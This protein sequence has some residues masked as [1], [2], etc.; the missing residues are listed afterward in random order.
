MT[1][2][3]DILEELNLTELKAKRESNDKENLSNEEKTILNIIEKETIHIDKICETSKMAANQVLSTISV[4]EIKGIIK[5]IGGGKF[6]RM[7]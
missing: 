2:V 6:V 3:D 4:L 5:N 7:K 1:S